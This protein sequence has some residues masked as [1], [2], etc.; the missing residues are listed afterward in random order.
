[1]KTEVYQE[2]W[3]MTGTEDEFEQVENLLQDANFDYQIREQ[4]KPGAKFSI[5]T[6]EKGEQ[7]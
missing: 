5:V 2:L 1:M 7:R 4:L 3:L 6:V